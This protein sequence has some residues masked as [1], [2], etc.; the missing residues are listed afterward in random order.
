MV[1]YLT[2]S[3]VDQ[4]L[5]ELYATHKTLVNAKH[6]T[7]GGGKEKEM[8]CLRLRY[9]DCVGRERGLKERRLFQTRQVSHLKHWEGAGEDGTEWRFNRH[10]DSLDI[11][12]EELTTSI[13]SMN[14]HPDHTRAL[15]RFVYWNTSRT[16]AVCFSLG[17]TTSWPC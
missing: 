12:D 11:T 16:G 1:S 5:Q 13:V 3:I 8:M 15:E 6:L 7:G 4:I 17:T 10:R 14:T 9:S 2:N